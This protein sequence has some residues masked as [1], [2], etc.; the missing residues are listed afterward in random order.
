MPLLSTCLYGLHGQHDAR[1][2]THTDARAYIHLDYTF[3]TASVIISA[4]SRPLSPHLALSNLPFLP[5]RRAGRTPRRRLSSRNELRPL[6]RSSQRNHSRLSAF[7]R[8]RRRLPSRYRGQFKKLI[9]GK[10]TSATECK[11]SAHA[12]KIALPLSR[13]AES[14]FVASIEIA[15]A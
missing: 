7:V 4:T 9:K 10:C 12:E 14:S 1:S 8:L 3:S 15:A 5:S 2:H 11:S 13:R 6:E